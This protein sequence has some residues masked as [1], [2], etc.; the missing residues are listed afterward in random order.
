MRSSTASLQQSDTS[1]GQR[2]PNSSRSSQVHGPQRNH[3]APSNP[4]TKSDSVQSPTH[5]TTHQPQLSRHTTSITPLL[6]LHLRLCRLLRLNS[7][8]VLL[9]RTSAEPHQEDRLAYSHFLVVL[10]SSNHIPSLG[11]LLLVPL[12]RLICVLLDSDLIL[13]HLEYV[14]SIVINNSEQ[15]KRDDAVEK[16]KR[17]KREFTWFA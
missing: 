15:V 13:A 9:Q 16:S 1:I 14:I 8:L 2:R 4:V 3:I 10:L 12:L 11:Q 6:I 5:H 7:S 17:E